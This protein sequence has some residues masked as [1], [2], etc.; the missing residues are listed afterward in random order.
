MSWIKH[1]PSLIALLLALAATIASCGGGT[2]GTGIQVAYVQGVMTKG[3]VIV[4]GIHFDDRS[5]VVQINSQSA[6]A[7]DLASG[8]YV[9][10]RGTINADGMTGVADTVQAVNE[11]RG[12]ITALDQGA[13]SLVV[14]GQSVLV[15][16]ATL[17]HNV[18]GLG[19][20]AIGQ[21][22]EVYGLR[23]ANGT[24]HASRIELLEAESDDELRGFVADLSG[25]T[26]TLNGVVVNYSSEMIRPLGATLANGKQAQVE[27]SFNDTS[28]AFTATMVWLGE[29]LPQPGMGER[30]EIEGFIANLNTATTSFSLNGRAVRY[31]ASTV[32]EH[33]VAANLANNVAVEVDGVVDS[34]G[35]LLAAKIEFE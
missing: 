6:T 2:D 19:S 8:M 12:A 28:G 26:F 35:V 22:I 23:D 33:G 1:R 5:A 29:G 17:F 27:G 21:Q 9:M 13:S 15:E 34:N 24:I 16:A 30:L 11:V 20:L 14:V 32:F 3:S 18:A 25:S 4:N 31:S 10:L 7:A